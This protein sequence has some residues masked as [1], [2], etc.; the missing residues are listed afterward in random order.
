MKE[1]RTIPI[2]KFIE[3]TLYNKKY[4]YYSKTNP[5]G[6]SGDYITAPGISFLFSEL[7]IFIQI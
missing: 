6:K 4:G 3:D 2:D 1:V 7:F 5:F